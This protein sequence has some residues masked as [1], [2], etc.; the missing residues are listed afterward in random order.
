MGGGGSFPAGV[1][2]PEHCEALRRQ[3]TDPTDGTDPC[4]QRR[5]GGERG[6]ERGLRGDRLRECPLLLQRQSEG[7]GEGE[8][9]TEK[10]GGAICEAAGM[11]SFRD[12]AVG[13]PCV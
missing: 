3:R 2:S 7:E 9:E 11:S 5:C 6:Q 13:C 10:E 4:V 1:E 8:G 12:L